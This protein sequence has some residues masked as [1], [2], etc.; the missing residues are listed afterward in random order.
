MN[1][2]NSNIEQIKLN[3]FYKDTLKIDTLLKLEDKD[4][5]SAPLLL[6]VFDSYLNSKIKIMFVG[7][8]TN[9]WLSHKSR[10]IEKRGINY[11]INDYEVFDELIRRYEKCLQDTNSK[12]SNRFFSKYNLFNKTFNNNEL[13]AIIWNNLYKCSYDKNRGYSKNSKGHSELLDELSKK[14]FNYEL[15]LLQPDVIVFVSGPTYDSTIKDFL[16]NYKKSEVMIK[17][18]LWKFE[19]ELISGI[20]KKDVICYRTIHPDYYARNQKIEESNYY[21]DIIDDIGVIRKYK[22]NK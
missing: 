2:K 17:R 19:Y 21:Q 13:G 4:N 15:E 3:D 10:P 5:L 12:T 18:R 22:S 14:L 8:E 6:K 1:N 9:H 7:K 20:E 16:G 11:L